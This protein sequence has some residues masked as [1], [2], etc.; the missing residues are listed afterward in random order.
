MGIFS[1]DKT[2]TNQ[3]AYNEQTAVSNRD[4]SGVQGTFG[5]GSSNNRVAIYSTSVDTLAL[6]TAADTINHAID[7]NT[8]TTQSTQAGFQNALEVVSEHQQSAADLAAGQ[9]GSLLGT[10]GLTSGQLVAGAAAVIGLVIL[11]HYLNR[12]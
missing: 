9:Q 6:K 5:A 11:M 1:Q 12:K 7:A 4:L 8:A 2:T 10:I 3:T